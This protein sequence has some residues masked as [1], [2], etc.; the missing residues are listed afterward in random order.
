[1]AIRRLINL[2]IQSFTPGCSSKRLISPKASIPLLIACAAASMTAPWP[3]VA[4]LPPAFLASS[5]A[6]RGIRRSAASLAIAFP[7]MA[8]YA[9]L[10]LITQLV[11]NS[12]SPTYILINSCRLASLVISSSTLS[13]MTRIYEIVELTSKLSP[14][15]ALMIALSLRYAYVTMLRLNELLQVY[16]VNLPSGRTSSIITRLKA[17]ASAVTYSCIELALDSSEAIHASGIRLPGRRRGP[18]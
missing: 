13:S 10:A 14:T 8:A 15:L 1:M 4:V 16:S 12:L 6:L 17:A 5:I 2:M 7:F 3:Y 11:T 9:A 18:A